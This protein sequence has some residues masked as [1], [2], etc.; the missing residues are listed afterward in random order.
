[1]M[2]I[3]CART[4]S[5]EWMTKP[6]PTFLQHTFTPKMIK[7]LSNRIHFCKRAFSTMHWQRLQNQQ[8]LQTN[9]FINGCWESGEN[10]FSVI[11]PATN[12]EIASVAS[13]RTK[14]VE[15]AIQ[16]AKAAQEN[17]KKTSPITRSTL[18]KKWF[19]AI[20]ENASDLATICA[21]ECGKPIKES[22]GEV[23]YAAGFIEFY[24]HELMRSAGF[25]VP[26]TV[27]GQQML[28]VKEPVGIC[29]II[30]PW[31][32]PL[33]MITRKI[34]PG[35][36]AG[37]CVIV[38]P[39]AETPLSALALAKLAS[40]VG[41]PSGVL[42]IL[43][44]SHENA[45][46][47]GSVLATHNDIRKLSFTGSTRVGKLLMQQ[48]STNVKRLSLELGGNAPFIVFEDAELDQAI[49][50]LIQSKFRNTGQTCVC[51]NRVFVQEDVYDIFA[52]KLVERVN[53]LK[54][55]NPLD[56][57]VKLGPLI[58]SAAL[59]KTSELVSDALSKGAKALI[60]GS[61]ATSFGSN[62]YHPTILENIS[63]EMRIA[64][65]EIFGPV[66]PLFKFKTEE[67][68]VGMA[69]STEFGLAG[70]FYSQNLKRVWRVSRSLECGMVG[71]NTGLISNVQAPFGGVK[72]SGLG[73]E[74]STL[75]LEEYLET[76]FICMAGLE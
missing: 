71:V 68:V 9:A 65:E 26:P 28:V 21:M 48:S 27:K 72:Q 38:K 69:N 2:N 49:E 51:S 32:F 1:M 34:G 44:T 76:K 20:T 53:K 29:A 39:A 50:G 36:A 35:L 54:M 62:Y 31:N 5:Q 4:Y 75:G 42:N 19:T 6:I 16:A 13:S 23:A 74:G 46:E 73:R 25:M 10:S 56:A 17:W 37:C 55:G 24:A 45:A 30:T 47:V 67:E 57:S 59:K 14:Q 41:I 12:K 7:Q 8:L 18:L 61:S 15:A 3:G 40:G 66:V 11:D 63:T 33:A 52:E 58:S 70:Y 22:E 60:G 43:P 64:S